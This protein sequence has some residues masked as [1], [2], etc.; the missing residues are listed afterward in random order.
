MR[1]AVTRPPAPGV[2][3]TMMVGLPGMKRL[4]CR[5]TTRAE[6]SLMPPGAVPTMR[7][8]ARPRQNCSTDGAGC[9]A[10]GP[11]H[12][13]QHAMRLRRRIIRVVIDDLANAGAFSG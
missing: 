1:F 2:V 3:W 7:V 11:A 12:G 8:T 4:R 13:Q 6:M 5:A 9:A 10:S